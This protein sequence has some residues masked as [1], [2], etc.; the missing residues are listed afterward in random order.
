MS[1][2]N[3]SSK[4]ILYSGVGVHYIE[5]DGY[6]YVGYDIEQTTQPTFKTCANKCFQT[7]G[8][9]GSAWSAD[10]NNICYLKNKITILTY[11][12]KYQIGIWKG[13]FRIE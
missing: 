12:R 1:N 5:V 4:N 8:C 2:K 6:N 9:V 7:S 3:K 11:D 10:L 13:T